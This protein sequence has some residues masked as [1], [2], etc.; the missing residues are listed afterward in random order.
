MKKSRKHKLTYCFKKCNN[1]NNNNNNFFPWYECIPTAN[2]IWQVNTINAYK[3][4]NEKLLK[5]DIGQQ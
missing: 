4:K 3:T 5:L 2:S 1:N